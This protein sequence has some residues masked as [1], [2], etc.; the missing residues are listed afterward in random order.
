LLPFACR[1]DRDLEQGEEL[2]RAAE[3]LGNS[4]PTASSRAERRSAFAQRGNRSGLMS[5]TRDGL[6]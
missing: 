5:P 2:R 1:L 3:R 6:V 4:N